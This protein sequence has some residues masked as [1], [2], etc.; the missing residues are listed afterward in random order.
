MNRVFALLALL[1]LSWSHVA[2]IPCPTGQSTVQGPAEAPMAHSHGASQHTGG[3]SSHSRQSSAY[4]ASLH[5]FLEVQYH[6]VRA[7]RGDVPP[8]GFPGKGSSFWVLSLGARPFL[9]GGPMR[10]GS[11]GVLDPMTMMGR[12]MSN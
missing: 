11:Y 1:A 9:G 5:P 7:E 2:A 10:M 6:R 4:P 3:E 12:M 8:D